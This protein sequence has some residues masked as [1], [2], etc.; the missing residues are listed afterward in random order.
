MIISRPFAL[1]RI[2]PQNTP[3]RMEIGTEMIAASTMPGIPTICQSDTRIRPISPAMAPRVMPKFSP[4]PAM[5]GI[6]RL[7]IRKEFLPIRVTISF[8]R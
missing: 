6:S 2:M 3:R 8:A 5:M 4:M 1:F 7:R